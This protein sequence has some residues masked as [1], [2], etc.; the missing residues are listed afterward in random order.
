MVDKF[1]V[2]IMRDSD[3]IF[4]YCNTGVESNIQYGAKICRENEAPRDEINKMGSSHLLVGSVLY[5][6]PTKY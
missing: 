5:S 3:V 2:P 1:L 4:Y 6:S